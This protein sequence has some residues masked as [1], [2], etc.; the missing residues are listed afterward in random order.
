MRTMI[1]CAAV[2]TAVVMTGA[3]LATAAAADTGTTVTIRSADLNTSDT[4][5][6]GHVTFLTD[7]LHAWT[8]D[9]SSQAKAAGY[10]AV[11]GPLPTSGSLTWF[12]TSPQPGAQIVVD[13]DNNGTADGILVGEP[14]YGDAWWLSNGSVQAL[15][16]GAPHTGGGYGSDWYG[17]LTEW[18]TSF[19][20]AH[21]LAGGFS[22][23]SGIKGDGVIDSITYG[24]TTYRFTSQPATP[25]P[26][27]KDV[28]GRTTVKVGARGFRLDLISSAQPANT[29]QGKK[30]TWRV[31]VDGKR[32]LT[33]V[34]GFGAHESLHLQFAKHS[35]KHAVKVYKNGVLGRHFTVK[36]A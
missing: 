15:K 11:T 23:G 22:L 29:V 6:A 21:I 8:D 10:F 35:G 27:V 24:S 17:T 33:S 2:I 25:A 32:V 1:K 20:D 16:D 7:G 34:Q 36:V 9:S 12:G 4:R 14:V 26:V 18:R 19:P 3:G 28:T 31:Y 30:L 13:Y 5:T